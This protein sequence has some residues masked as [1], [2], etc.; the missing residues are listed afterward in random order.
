DIIFLQKRDH[1][2]TVEPDWVHLGQNDDGF[3]INSYFVDHPEMILGRQTSESTQYGKQ[4][5]TVEPIEGLELKDQLADAVKYIR[6]TYKEAE[7]P[8]LGEEESIRETIPADPN[9]KNYSYTIV[10]GDVY[11][12]ENSV[13]VKP[14]LN[15][16]AQ[17]RVKGLV[18]LRNCV[19]EL[20]DLQMDEYVPDSAIREKQAELNGLYDSFTAKYGL[21]NDRANKLAFSDDSSYYL[22]C[23][24]EILDDERNFKAKADIFSK[25][26][27][28]P[29]RSIDHVD[30]PVEALAVSIGEKAC[31][32]LPYMAQL[33]GKT[34]DEVTTELRGIIFKDPA[35]GAD[36]LKGWQTADE[37]LSG[38]VRSKLRIA[39]RAAD[40]DPA[41]QINVEAL[42]KAQPKDLDA[43]EIE[44][45][46]GATWIDKQYIQQ[47]MEETFNPPYYLR[48][49]IQVN[50]SPYTAEWQITGKSMCSYNDVNAYVTYGTDR[51][52]AYRLLEDAL[53]LRDIRIYDTVEDADGKERRVLNAKETTLAAQKQQAIRDAF[54]DWIWRDP[55][56]RQTLVTQYNEEMNSTRPREYDG[57]H[58]VFSGMNPEIT[59]RE[60]QRNAIA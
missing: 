56:R 14:D 26:T 38:N 37:Y 3:A 4:D 35:M 23:S 43:S 18:A 50:Y 30:T 60:H 6:G 24:L 28:K 59:L 52:N 9:V 13:M 49:N 20:I 7:L 42:E 25:R 57:S 58:I 19:H 11:F 27:I 54:K 53:N 8:D 36:P 21:I 12:R 33:C 16:T 47:F 31:V 40:R 46:L 55:D 15:A 22:L 51:A 5:F 32:D 34:T 10:D 1:P 44:V 29:Q 39:Q 48:R 45:R 41:F 2:V 17:E